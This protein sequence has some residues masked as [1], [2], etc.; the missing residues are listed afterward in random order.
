MKVIDLF[1]G[2]GGFSAA[3][4]ARGH[5]VTTLDMEPRF[6]PDI[7]ADIMDIRPGDLPPSDVVLASPPCQTFS[8]ATISR[9]WYSPGV[10]KTQAA[11][12]GIEVVRHTL[13]LI[14]SMG[15]RWWVMENPDAMLKR[16]VGPPAA[17]ITL[18]QYGARW[19]KRT[20]LWGRFPPSAIRP[21]CRRGSPCHEP[22]P[23]GSVSG[24]QGVRDPALRAMLPYGLSEALC[25][26]M[27]TGR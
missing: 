16:V 18:C 19:Q 3:F 4:V 21:P 8:V 25:I 24:V 1:S 27:E 6:R 7:E 11:V 23:R 26:S 15:P 5:D 14:G 9:H 20:D 12:R 17:V 10:P 13:R 2:L 22:A